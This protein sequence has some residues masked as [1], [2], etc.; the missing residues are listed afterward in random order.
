MKGVSVEQIVDIVPQKDHHVIA[1]QI[2]Y[3]MQKQFIYE[4]TPRFKFKTDFTEDTEVNDSYTI[5]Q[6]YVSMTTS[7]YIIT[8]S[9]KYC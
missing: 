2:N 3:F 7:I 5:L 8:N 1:I 6:I 9:F 4:Q